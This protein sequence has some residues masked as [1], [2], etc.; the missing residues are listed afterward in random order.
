MGN[1][2]VRSISRPPP[3]RRQARAVGTLPIHGG[4]WVGARAGGCF[5]PG[6]WRRFP[7]EARDGGT[8]TSLLWRGGAGMGGAPPALL[9]TSRAYPVASELFPDVHCLLIL[10]SKHTPLEGEVAGFFSPSTASPGNPPP[11]PCSSMP[12]QTGGVPP[13]A[14]PAARV[15]ERHPQAGSAMPSNA[16]VACRPSSPCRVG[17]TAQRQQSAA[18]STAR[19]RQ[20]RRHLWP[21]TRTRVIAN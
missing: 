16:P 21:T 5:R 6:W 13:P 15:C 3:Q 17:D 9:L 4:G 10:L 19:G 2:F 20:V 8:P 1:V 14:T 11:T 12:P 18:G 7:P